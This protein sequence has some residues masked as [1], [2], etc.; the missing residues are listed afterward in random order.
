[1]EIIN[2]EE[3]ILDDRGVIEALKE[4]K[5]EVFETLNTLTAEKKHLAKMDLE[6]PAYKQVCKVNS[7]NIYK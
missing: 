6:M 1:L 7:N 5:A 3:D 2:A 4:A